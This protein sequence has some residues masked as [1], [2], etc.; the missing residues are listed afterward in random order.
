[1]LKGDLCFVPPTYHTR[2]EKDP[3]LTND[4]EDDEDMDDLTI[5]SSDTVLV[6]ATTEVCIF[7][8]Q[9]YYFFKKYL[10]CY[11]KSRKINLVT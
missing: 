10:I 6:A 5:K 1:M 11:K 9:I 3:L 8:K 4:G 7:S 2:G